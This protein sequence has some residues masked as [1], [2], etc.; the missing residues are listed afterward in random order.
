MGLDCIDDLNLLKFQ[1][2]V[3]F[4]RNCRDRIKS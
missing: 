3:S 4:V 2:G 1:V